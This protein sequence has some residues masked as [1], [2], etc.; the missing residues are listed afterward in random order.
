MIESSGDPFATE[1]PTRLAALRDLLGRLDLDA[2]LV[3]SRTTSRY[4]SG[5][6]VRRGDESTSGYSGSLLVTTDAAR[7]L[8]D[9]RYVEQATAE[10]PGWEVVLTSD[11]LPVELPRLLVPAAIRRL[12]LEAERT[13]HA[14]WQA[15]D[16]SRDDLELVPVDQSLAVLRITKSPA[17]VDAIGRACALGDRAFTYLCDT[18]QPG[19]TERSVARLIASYFEDHG[20]EDLAFDSIVLVGARASMPHG[21]PGATP[22][23]AGQPLLLD[24]GCQV[25]G[26]R[27]DMTRTVFVGE[28]GEAARKRHDAVVQAQRAAL[29]AVAV[30]VAASVPHEAARDSLAQAGYPE[31][32]SHGV[33]H[34]IGLDTHEPPALK[35]TADTP[36]QAGMVFSIEPGLYLPGEIGIRIEDIVALT[37]AGPRFLTHAPREAV[38]IGQAVAA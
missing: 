4:L 6:T 20:A 19:M 33:G 13:S 24:F 15:L 2:I 35:K 32:F 38:V 10:A 34:G 23:E 29:G 36:L 28:P 21:T 27:S 3:Q 11:P 31:A 26:Y 9:N 8:V 1:R 37:D 7:L 25:D 30:G 17:E 12:G 18:V 22:V 5:F 16:A 14:V